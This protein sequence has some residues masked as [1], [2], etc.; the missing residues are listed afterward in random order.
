MDKDFNTIYKFSSLAIAETIILTSTL[1]FSNP[2]R[3]NDPFDCDISRLS[4]EF[5]KEDP[6]ILKE[7]EAIRTR[8]YPGVEFTTKHFEEG[9]RFAQIDKIRR[10]SVCC[11]SSVND[12]LLLWAHYGDKH[13]GA[14]LVFDNTLEDKFVNIPTD[15]LSYVIVDYKSFQRVNYFKNQM[16]ALKNLFGTKSEDWSYEKEFRL[17]LLE[18]E[19]LFRFKPAFLK[20]IIFGL[21]VPYEE[22]DRFKAACKRENINI[23]FK[24]AERKLDAVII[25][26]IF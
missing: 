9:F 19:G 17:I 6:H 26:D 23:F 1:K 4:F 18:Q 10:S 2:S 21:K 14:C 12:N 25:T 22:I 11:F 16:L 8:I 13:Q 15:N 5:S 3:F 7:I 20:G 24:K